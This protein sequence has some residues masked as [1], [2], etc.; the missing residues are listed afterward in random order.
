MDTDPYWQALD[1][2]PD[3]DQP[4]PKLCQYDWIRIHNTGNCI[5]AEICLFFKYILHFLVDKHIR[6]K[7]FI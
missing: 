4:L 5:N 3:Q 6:E 1:A 2:D 7:S